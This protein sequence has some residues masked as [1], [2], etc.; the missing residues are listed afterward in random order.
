MTTNTIKLH[1]KTLIIDTS[2]DSPLV[3]VTNGGC[4]QS[5]NTNDVNDAT[6]ATET[7]LRN[8]YEMRNKESLSRGD[9]GFSTGNVKD[10]HLLS[11]TISYYV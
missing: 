10:D 5:S 6:T 8:S 11:M 2:R 7:R 1:V 9:G 4:I 3:Q